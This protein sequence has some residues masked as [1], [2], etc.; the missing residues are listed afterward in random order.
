MNRLN[1]ALLG[2]CLL[3]PMAAVAQDGVDYEEEIVVTGTQIKGAQISDALPVSV[4]DQQQ[5]EALGLMSGD[6]LLEHIA[7]QG[8][9][10]F[11]KPRTS[12]VA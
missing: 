8:Q 7:E 12:A 6:E 4:I 11:T 2:L 1:G 10:Q 3:T 5:I 9:N